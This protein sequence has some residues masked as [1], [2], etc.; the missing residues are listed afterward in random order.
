MAG[1]VWEWCQDWHDP[2]EYGRR[3]SGLTIDPQGPPDGKVHVLRG[4]CWGSEPAD[5]RSATRATPYGN[6]GS[7]YGFRAAISVPAVKQA[8]ARLSA[9]KTGADQTAP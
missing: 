3:G 9:A 2:H 4:G 6:R 8:L 1:N 7:G 5:L